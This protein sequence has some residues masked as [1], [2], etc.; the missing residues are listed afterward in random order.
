MFL[1]FLK[2]HILGIFS[3][4]RK[5]LDFDKNKKKYLLQLEFL[6]RR[7]K[8]IAFNSVALSRALNEPN[9]W[10]QIGKTMQLLSIVAAAQCQTHFSQSRESNFLILQPF[11][12]AL[13][14]NQL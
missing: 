1:D 3:D 8:R 13:A 4:L 9:L 12:A 7:L 6:K 10:P 2:T 14:L 5:E 11:S